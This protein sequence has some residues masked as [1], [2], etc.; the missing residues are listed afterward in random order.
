LAL[1][2]QDAAGL[3]LVE[4]DPVTVTIGDVTLSLP[5]KLDPGLPESVAGLPAGLPRMPIL[6]L[7][8]YG[9]IAKGKQDD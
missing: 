6:S 7:P 5:V 2:P 4:G 9:T 3:S 8:A 1:H